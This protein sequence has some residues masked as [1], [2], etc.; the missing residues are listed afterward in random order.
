MDRAHTR[1]KDSHAGAAVTREAT[2]I[3]GDGIGPEI[4]QVTLEVL[5]AL[6]VGFD[7]DEQY[8]GI[9]AGGQAGT[10]LPHA[11]GEPIP[12]TRPGPEGPLTTPP[13]DGYPAGE[14]A[15]RPEVAMF[16]H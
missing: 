7:W 15:A 16:T 4:T 11:T 10:P 2:L 3:A 5:D 12:R 8:G 14:L 13:G 1:G 6:G 9:S